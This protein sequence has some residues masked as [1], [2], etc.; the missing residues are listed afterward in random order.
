M[1]EIGEPI[2]DFDRTAFSREIA[3][4]IAQNHERS[5][6]DMQAGRVLYDAIAIAYQRGL[7]L[8]AELTLLAKTLFSLDAITR[9]L[10][11]AY[12]PTEAIRSYTSEIINDRARRDLSPARLARAV[13]QTS[14]LAERAAASPRSHHAAPGGERLRAQDRCAADV[15]GAQGNAEDREPDLH[16]PR[17]DWPAGRERPV[18]QPASEARH[19]RL[20][21]GRAASRSTWSSRSSC[22]TG[23]SNKGDG[24]LAC[25]IPR[26]CGP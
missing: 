19:D 8:P 25:P 4:L 6:G 15:D 24:Q 5:I 11:P 22:P 9:A 23:D 16:G 17:A 26:D 1:I 3:S 18:D 7:K 10:D 12:N 13:A 2:D 21:A 20:P 14:E